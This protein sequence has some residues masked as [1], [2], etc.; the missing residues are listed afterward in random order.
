LTIGSVDV[1][2]TVDGVVESTQIDVMPFITDGCTYVPVRFLSEQLGLDVEWS[3][4]YRTVVL[5]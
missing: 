4:E 1:K 5:R 3:A 2:K